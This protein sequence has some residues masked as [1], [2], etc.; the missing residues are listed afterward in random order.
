MPEN[1]ESQ[2]TSPQVFP[3]T[4]QELTMKLGAQLLEI[5][6]QRKK[7]VKKDDQLIEILGRMGDLTTE[8]VRLQDEIKQLQEGTTPSPSRKERRRK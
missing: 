5:D 6:L 2:Q 8:N 1:T 4:I 7:V 3:F